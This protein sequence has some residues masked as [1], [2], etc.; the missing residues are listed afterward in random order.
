MTLVAAYERLIGG[1]GT[2][3][4][5]GQPAPPIPDKPPVILHPTPA[6]EAA[7]T[8]PTAD[9]TPAPPQKTDEKSAEPEKPSRPRVRHRHRKKRPKEAERVILAAVCLPEC[10][11]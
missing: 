9:A 6:P 2:E 5:P 10:D 7:S 11:D 3:I 1:R 4:L 8:S